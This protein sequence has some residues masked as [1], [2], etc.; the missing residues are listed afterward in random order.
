MRTG[1]ERTRSKLNGATRNPRHDAAPDAGGMITSRI[2]RTRATPAAFADP[3][4][5]EPR[6][7]DRQAGAGLE[8]VHPPGLH[9]RGGPDGAFLDKARLGG[10]PAHVERYHAPWPRKLSE[11]RGR[12]PASRRAGFEQADRELA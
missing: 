1:Y 11:Q 3:G 2:P 7:F 8:A 9:R 12:K 5:A 10:G 4:P 6:R